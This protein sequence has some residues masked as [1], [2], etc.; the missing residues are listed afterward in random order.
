AERGGAEVDEVRQSNGIDGGSKIKPIELDVKSRQK[1]IRQKPSK[2]V[3]PPSIP[4]RNPASQLPLPKDEEPSRSPSE[5]P[6]P[7]QVGKVSS[8][9]DR[10]KAQIAELKASMKRNIPSA[11]ATESRKKSAVEQ[12]MPETATRGRKRKH[13]AN[14]DMQSLEFL[15]AF[16]AKLESAPLESKASH[17]P[18]MSIDDAEGKANGNVITKDDEDEEAALCD[19]HF[20]ANCQSCQSWEKQ[21][22]DDEDAVDGD[23]KGWMSHA[24][25]FDKD[26]LGKDLNW[27]KKNEDELVVID[28]REKAKDLKEE[29]RA[30]RQKG[31]GRAWDQDRDRG[32]VPDRRADTD[33]RPEPP[34][35]RPAHFHA[36][37]QRWDLA[38][39]NPADFTR[40]SQT[41]LASSARE[42]VRHTLRQQATAQAERYEIWAHRMGPPFRENH[43]KDAST[44]LP[45][46]IIQPHRPSI[47]H[48]TDGVGTISAM[49]ADKSTIDSETVSRPFRNFRSVPIQPDAAAAANYLESVGSKTAWPRKHGK[50]IF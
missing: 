39:R 32:R 2:S 26:R 18:E 46:A 21:L 15:K 38:N 9:L 20:I 23:D 41:G 28:P 17:A 30:K 49:D 16:R 1:P 37:L 24:L 4:P 10:T 36:H 3:S 50:N 12:M 25:N 48:T 8:L 6:E 31:G 7:E 34:R 29:Q 33:R 5:S 14:G 42:P 19:L 27:K 44:D 11:P 47:V 35:H 22:P 13:G 43:K 40:T 45:R